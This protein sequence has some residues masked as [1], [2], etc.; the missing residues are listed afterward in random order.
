MH[1]PSTI[2]RALISVSDK[3]GLLPFAETLFKNG[4]EIIS[5]GG[6]AKLLQEHDIPVTEISEFTGFPEMMEGRL[7]TLHPKVHGG[8]LG[9]RDLDSDIMHE[10]DIHDIDL[11]VVNLYPFESTVADP[12]CTFSH[13]I[14]NIDIGGPTLLRAAAKNHSWVTVVVDPSDY[15]RILDDMATHQ[16]ATSSELRFELATKVFEHTA[17]YDGAIANYFGAILPNG[18]KHDFPN[19]LSL[20]FKLDK[21]LRYGENP[22]QKAALYLDKKPP[23]GTIAS[24][25][26]L[27]GKPLSFN[28]IN[29]AEG[30]LECVKQFD[31]PACVIVKHANPCGVAISS[32]V[33][34]AYQKA[35]ACDPESSFGGIIAF[36]QIVDDKALKAIFD[37]QFVEV[38]IAPEFTEPALKLAESKINLRLLTTGKLSIPSKIIS[39]DI[40]RIHGGILVQEFDQ[41]LIKTSD[42]N[43]VSEQQPTAS[44]VTD[45]IFAMKAAQYV[46][47]NAIVLARQGQTIGIG[48]GQMSRVF[49]LKI[50]QMRAKD[51]SFNTEDAVLASDAFFP[52]RDSI[53]LAA[54][55]GIKAII[56][57]SGSKRDEEVIQA[58][59]EHKMVL[60]FIATR[61]F[62]H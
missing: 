49:A 33:L 55:L 47:S 1:L 23:T 21:T 25:T 11:V 20:Q 62:K 9:R 43:F 18:E 34:T 59:N 51:A 3:T 61:H 7:K 45:L 29:D 17:A 4:I 48:A 40:K 24:A 8:I 60:A 35:Y 58:A 13:A 5:T 46:K 16:G 6:T 38:I 32:D 28:N 37:N 57:P 10:H 27:Q 44:E 2:Q 50:A 42:L 53:D 14:E 52:F 56:Q 41:I 30:A 31:Q 54:K 12:R 15:Q 39:H 19:T 26:L 22:H 36:N